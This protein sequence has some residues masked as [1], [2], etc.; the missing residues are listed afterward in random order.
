MLL[1]FS[2]VVFSF[3]EVSEMVSGQGF[4]FAQGALKQR[5]HSRQSRWRARRRAAGSVPIASLISPLVLNLLK[6][7]ETYF[8]TPFRVRSRGHSWFLNQTY[9]SCAG[10]RPLKRT[11]ATRT[12]QR[13]VAARRLIATSDFVV[14]RS[15]N[16]V[17]NATARRRR[18]ARNGRSGSRGWRRRTRGKSG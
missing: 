16:P 10:A 13:Q 15:A 14:A 2:F 12:R 6:V 18:G 5:P 7:Y 11:S 17:K 8:I 1:V 4:I 3:W 9:S